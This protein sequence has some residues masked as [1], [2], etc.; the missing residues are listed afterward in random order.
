MRL[1]SKEK[2]QLATRCHTGESATEIR[3]D[4]GIARSTFYTWIRT[5]TATAVNSEHAASWQEFIKLKQRI[6]KLEY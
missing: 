6:P 2:K 5:Y 4:A 3:A 1:S